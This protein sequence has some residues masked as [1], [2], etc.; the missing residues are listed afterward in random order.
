MNDKTKINCRECDW[1]GDS[2]TPALLA[3]NPFDPADLVTGCP[4]CRS[5]NSL[6]ACC[7]AP[8]CREPVSCGT[9]TPDGY[10]S[11]CGNHRPK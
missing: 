8:G 2:K 3:A 10:R 7:D 6:E 9:P 5:V 1:Q 11:T 4:Q